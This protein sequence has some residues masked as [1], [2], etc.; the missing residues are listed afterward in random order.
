MMAEN[1][2]LTAYLLELFRLTDGDPA[3][4]VSMFDVGAAM[5]MEKSDAGKLAEELIGQGWAEVRTLSGGIGITAQGIEAALS[6]GAQGAS[7]TE[8]L[9]LGSGPILD[10]EGLHC[11]EIMLTAIKSNLAAIEPE[12]T[13]MEELVIDVKTI[14]V[15]LLSPRPKTAVLRE[16]LHSLQMN[17]AQAKAGDLAGR[18]ERMIR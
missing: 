3:V 1:Q 17:F 15:Q 10:D 5:G 8:D 7:A 6:A 18:L 9:K 2:D 4:Q 13:R 11:L 16:I 14:E 12:Y